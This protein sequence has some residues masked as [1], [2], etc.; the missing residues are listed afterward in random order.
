VKACP[1]FEA[2]VAPAI[3][4]AAGPLSEFRA[5]RHRARCA[6]C[7]AATNRLNQALS[8]LNLPADMA[9][10]SPVPLI[11]PANGDVP[12]ARLERPADRSA[13]GSLAPALALWSV[14]V[15]IAVAGGAL[16]GI[17]PI[18]AV[19]DLLRPVSGGSTHLACFVPLISPVFVLSLL[20]PV[21]ILGFSCR[22]GQCLI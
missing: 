3:R 10:L 20:A 22:E 5:D 11:V 14:L 18:L 8:T 6:G 19:D 9:I 7:Q 2:L 1:L 4:E 12:P 13:W 15:L 16:V 17:H 21:L